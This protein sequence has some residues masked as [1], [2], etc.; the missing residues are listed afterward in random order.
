MPGVE[1]IAVSCLALACG[2][3]CGSSEPD[4]PP[5]ATPI[6]VREDVTVP[7]GTVAVT[8]GFDDS[9]A[10]HAMAADMLEAHGMR[11]TFYVILSRLGGEDHLTVEQVHDL[12]VRGH[13]IAGHTFTHRNL[14]MLP[15][16]EATRELCDARVA[17]AELGWPVES[18]AYPFGELSDELQD[19]ARDCGYS[20][21][22]RVGGVYDAEVCQACPKA[23]SIPPVLPFDVQTPT[24]V[25]PETTLETM[26]SWVTEAEAAG[27]GWIDIVYHSVCDDCA[28]NA[29]SPAVLEGFLAWLESREGDGVIVATADQVVG[30]ATGAVVVGPP[31]ARTIDPEQM[32]A[33]PS[34]ETW[35]DPA[36]PPECWIHGPEDERETWTRTGDAYAGS[37]AQEVTVTVPEG[38]KPTTRLVTAQDMGTCAIPAVPGQCFTFKARYKGTAIVEPV[39]YV[40][41]HLGNWR[42]WTHGPYFAAEDDWTEARWETIGVPDDGTAVSF[43]LTL[44]DG[45][46]VFFDDLSLGPRD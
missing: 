17:M 45:G 36:Q 37:Y 31:P 14:P 35:E 21:A 27:G 2:A 1:R 6:A 15:L 25:T 10:T 9:F 44:F 20:S 41:D 24:S 22:R 3:G 23:E 19:A 43:G 11:G 12:G 7:A 30:G 5:D 40:R 39:A 33:N 16:D 18:F 29:V 26:Q 13:E 38:E 28:P 8:L 32:L 46:E 34:L 42:S 4:P